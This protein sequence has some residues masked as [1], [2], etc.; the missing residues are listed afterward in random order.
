MSE[1]AEAKKQA[2]QEHR[3]SFEDFRPAIKRYIDGRISRDEM[4]KYWLALEHDHD[5]DMGLRHE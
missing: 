2:E 3:H 1:L 5:I 4:E